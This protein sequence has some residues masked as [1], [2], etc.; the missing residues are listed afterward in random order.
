MKFSLIAVATI[1]IAGMAS[2]IHPKHGCTKLVQGNSVTEIAEKF[3]VPID[4]LLS[5]N[6]GLKKDTAIGGRS[7]CVSTSKTQV[8][9]TKKQPKKK[10]PKKKGPSKPTKNKRP[11]KGLSTKRPASSVRRVDPKCNLWSLVYSTDK[12]CAQFASEN[13]I[14][15]ERLY[16]LNPGLHRVGEHRCD[17]LDTNKSYC[18]ST[19]R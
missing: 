6:G 2:A 19:R 9:A 7:V 1:A 5:L 13:G 4:T 12:D 16:D 11:A 8:K 15:E 10:Q 17:N 3:N 18:V 14:G